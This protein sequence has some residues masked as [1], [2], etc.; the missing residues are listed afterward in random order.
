MICT[1]LN[2][3][4]YV[5]WF[6]LR[7]MTCT[8]LNDLHYADWFFSVE[9]FVQRWKIRTTL[10]DLYNVEW[11]ALRWKICTTVN[12][13]YFVKR[14]VQRWMRP[15]ILIYKE[16]RF[17]FKIFLKSLF[18]APKLHGPKSIKRCPNYSN[19]A[20]EIISLI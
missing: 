18:W 9:W 2:N 4:Y 19:S 16:L 14:F 11:F 12:D 20:C 7:W 17:F 6:V 3:L 1:T 5:E 10:N 13:L 15:F 8:T